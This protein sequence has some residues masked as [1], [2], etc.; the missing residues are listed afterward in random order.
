MNTDESINHNI[1]AIQK[2][3][4][5]ENLIISK[6]L[7]PVKNNKVISNIINISEELINYQPVI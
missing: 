1:I 2:Q 3:G 6:S 5:N 7:G 4:I